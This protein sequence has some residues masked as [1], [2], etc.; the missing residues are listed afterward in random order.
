MPYSTFATLSHRRAP[1]PQGR[2]NHSADY[3]PLNRSIPYFLSNFALLINVCKT[4]SPGTY[5]LHNCSAFRYYIQQRAMRRSAASWLRSRFYPNSGR[6]G[7]AAAHRRTVVNTSGSDG[8][9]EITT[10]ARV[11]AWWLTTFRGYAVESK[12][13]V[14][15]ESALGKIYY[16][17]RW[18]LTKQKDE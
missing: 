11:R 1:L 18:V 13:R 5:L 12:R 2:P 8:K 15:H 7:N 9:T 3:T 14:P 17:N 6:S 4:A 10:S 16:K